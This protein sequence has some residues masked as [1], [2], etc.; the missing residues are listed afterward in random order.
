MKPFKSPDDAMWRYLFDSLPFAVTHRWGGDWDEF[1]DGVLKAVARGDT[2]KCHDPHYGAGPVPSMT[3][4]LDTLR[5]LPPNLRD[6]VVSAMA[7]NSEHN[8]PDGAFP[9][10]SQAVH[11]EEA[12]LAMGIRPPTQPFPDF[13]PVRQRPA[14]KA[15]LCRAFGI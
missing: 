15:F 3:V 12:L 9:P 6:A 10:W 11:V 8:P 4:H 7:F 5:R 2:G 1:R 13:E 14:W